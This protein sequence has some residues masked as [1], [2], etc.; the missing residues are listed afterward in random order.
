MKRQN[1][2]VSRLLISQPKPASNKSPYFK[3]SE[4][5]GVEVDFKQFIKIEGVPFKE[6][7]KEKIDFL[8]Y[9][10]VIFTSRNAVDY[11]FEI[12]AEAKVEMPADMK[13]FCVSEQTANYLQK[14]ITIRKRKLFVGNKTAADLIPLIAKH[15]EEKFIFPCSD[16]RKGE[17]PKYLSENSIE[18]TEAVLYRTVAADLSDIDV[19]AYD[20]IAFFS[21]SGVNS[22]KTNFPDF[23][24]GD[25]RI[26]AF[27]PTTAKAV[28]E[29][30]LNLNIQAPMPNAPSMTG[31]I[32]LYI[33]DELG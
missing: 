4:A 6:F 18:Y 28:E 30:G 8:D 27:G 29:N 20:M 9:T 3:L 33:K 10:A 26:A 31:A 22:L 24:Q 23:Q 13:Y 12:C 11:Y 16:I 25:V 32:E 2:K 1:K 14:Y 17:I 5:Y 21:P 7:R 15:P 19:H